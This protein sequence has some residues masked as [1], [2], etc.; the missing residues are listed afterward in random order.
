[1]LYILYLGRN[2]LPEP[3]IETSGPTRIYLLLCVNAPGEAPSSLSIFPSG[4]SFGLQRVK[5]S[6]TFLLQTTTDVENDH[7]NLQINRDVCKGR[8]AHHDALDYWVKY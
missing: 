5:N 2:L 4:G 1:M 3:V 8:R 6:L 7:D